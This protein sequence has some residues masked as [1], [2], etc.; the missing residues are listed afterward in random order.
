MCPVNSDFYC[1]PTVQALSAT[2]RGANGATSA[3][4]FNVGNVDSLDPRFSA[5]SEVSGPNPG[6]FDWGLG[7]FFGRTVYTA[8]EGAS[9]PGGQGPYFAY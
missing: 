6:G 5:F 2:N 7:F 3:V 9:T 8:I 1:P 4:S